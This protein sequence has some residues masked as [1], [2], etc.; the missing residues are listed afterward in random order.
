[1]TIAAPG[2]LSSLSIKEADLARCVAPSRSPF[3]GSL[4]RTPQRHAKLASVSAARPLPRARARSAD[5]T[6]RVRRS[7]DEAREHILA[8]AATVL[9]QKGPDG[10]GLKDVARQAGV[11]HALV[12]HYFGTY[13][14]LVEAVMSWHQASIRNALFARMAAHPEAGPDE[15]LVLLFEA[16]SQPMY[17]RLAAWAVL[18]GRIDSEG[19]FTKRD[20]GLQL[21]ADVLEARLGVTGA[22]SRERIERLLLIVLS[23]AVGYVFGRNALWGALGHETT[24]ARDESYRTELAALIG[25][26][27]EEIKALGTNSPATRATV[28]EASDKKRKR[29]KKK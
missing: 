19:F 26:A 24:V 1:M 11:S 12:S 16:V 2:L 25:P 14:A 29:T 3:D 18:T 6:P 10:A 28:R 20:R 27:I 22:A 13:D 5:Q 7:P 4:A 17:G 9:A 8:S 21:V 15:W 23:A